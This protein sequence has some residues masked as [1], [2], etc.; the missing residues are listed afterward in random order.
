[1]S[2]QRRLVSGHVLIWEED[3]LTYRL[4]T[5]LSMEEAVAIAESLAEWEP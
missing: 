1:M 3:G 4:E 5:D 2:D